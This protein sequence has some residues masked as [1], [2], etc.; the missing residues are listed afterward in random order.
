MFP[1]TVTELATGA[2]NHVK[3]TLFADLHHEVDG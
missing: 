3:N 2:N 1:D